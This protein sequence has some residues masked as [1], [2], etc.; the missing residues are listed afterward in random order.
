MDQLRSPI[1][2]LAQLSGATNHG[3]EGRET[4]TDAI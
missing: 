1:G 4:T 3:F 2:G